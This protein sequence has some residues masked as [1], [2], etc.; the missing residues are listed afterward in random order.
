MNNQVNVNNEIQKTS[1]QE[2]NGMVNPAILSSALQRINDIFEMAK[3]N[4]ALLDCKMQGIQAGGTSLRKSI[5][6]DTND[7]VLM[8]EENVDCEL[9]PKE[10][11]ERSRKRPATIQKLIA[12]KKPRLNKVTSI[13]TTTASTTV[14]PLTQYFIMSLSNSGT[15]SSGVDS[16]HSNQSVSNS[17]AGSPAS[18][19]KEE[20][21]EIKEEAYK[22]EDTNVSGL[23]AHMFSQFDSSSLNLP[24][25]PPTRVPPTR[26]LLPVSS[27]PIPT[28]SRS[29][30]SPSI[31][32]G[33]IN[34]VIQDPSIIVTHD[35]L[36]TTVPRRLSLLSVSSKHRVTVGEILRRITG[37]ESINLSLLGVLL[38]RA[39]MPSKSEQ[40]IKELQDVGITIERGRRRCSTMTTMSA[41]LETESLELARDLKSVSTANFPV[42]LLA[43]H[44]VN[45]KIEQ[46]KPAMEDRLQKLG[47]AMEIL[48]EFKDTLKSDRAP[49]AEENLPPILKPELQEPLSNYSMLTHGFGTPA[50]TVGIETAI[51]YIKSQVPEINRKLNEMQ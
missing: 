34:G 4:Q 24:N 44:S 19:I 41:L 16:E 39:K 37:P 27:R 12:D 26:T 9:L 48:S 47:W 6:D 35:T 32:N 11:F 45:H 30:P 43:E 17:S 7:D 3:N 33:S 46:T 13:N 8:K 36:F 49:V 18:Q 15:E 1:S 50:I 10:N 40:L 23:I 51:E 28:P 42:R 14:D 25:V 21:P 38:R 2:K 31:A 29:N 20:I 22:A 5:R